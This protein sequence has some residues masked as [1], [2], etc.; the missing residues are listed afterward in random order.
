MQAT[1]AAGETARICSELLFGFVQRPESTFGPDLETFHA[2]RA[3][4]DASLHG[5]G[6]AKDRA[7]NALTTVMIPEA[8]DYPA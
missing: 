2:M 3:K 8:L 4:L 6:L 7:A 1:R 5:Y